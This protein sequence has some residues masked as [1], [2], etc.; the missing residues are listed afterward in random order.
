[1]EKINNDLIKCPICKQVYSQGTKYCPL[2]MYDFSYVET[3][4]E[5]VPIPQSPQKPSTPPVPT[6]PLCCSTA[7]TAGARG[8]NGFL[9]FIGAS[10]TVNRCANC[11]NTWTPRM[12]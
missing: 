3:G 2:C 6:C 7:I 9:G 1:M 10:K 4:I 12:K 11:G 8:V 5:S